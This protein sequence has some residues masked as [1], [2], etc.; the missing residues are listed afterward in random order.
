MSGA[1]ADTYFDSH[2][3]QVSIS[4]SKGS[5]ITGLDVICRQCV[6]AIYETW[7]V[8]RPILCRGDADVPDD[9][10]E[11][12]ED[13]T[14]QIILNASWRAIKEARYASAKGLG[15]EFLLISGHARSN[16]LSVVLGLPTQLRSSLWSKEEL[17][18]HASLFPTWL[19]DIT[20]RGVFAHVVCQR[21]CTVPTDLSDNPISPQSQAYSRLC[22]TLV[23]EKASGPLLPETW[24]KV[25]SVTAAFH[26]AILIYSSSN[27][28]LTF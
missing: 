15:G 13:S 11:A 6:D 23:K 17:S 14:D 10:E 2:L 27:I 9:T 8:T 20:H 26:V 12:A 1:P 24:L 25:G 4:V 28:S 3:L 19:I 22:M 16:L 21:N 7:E 18:K 5:S